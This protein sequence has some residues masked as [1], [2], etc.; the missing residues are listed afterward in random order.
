MVQEGIAAFDTVCHTYT[1]PLGREEIIGQKD[2]YFNKL[3]LVQQWPLADLASQG[4]FKID[5]GIVAVDL[6]S[7]VH[8]QSSF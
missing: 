1:V 2:F 4:F 8:H 6:L 3:S 5:N 7:P